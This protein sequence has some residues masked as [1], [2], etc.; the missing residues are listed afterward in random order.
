MIDLTG[1][2]ILVTGASSGIGRQVAITLSSLGAAVALTGR[3]EQRLEETSVMLSGKHRMLLP[4]DLS[5]D[6]NHDDLVARFRQSLGPIDGFVHAAGLQIT[7]PLRKMEFVDYE[8]LMRVNVFAALALAK[9]MT[10]NSHLSVNGGS[11]VFV[12]SVMG[13]LSR[14]ALTAYSASK[15]A[16]LSGAKALALELSKKKVRVN[17][18]LPG[19]VMTPL[20]EKHVSYLDEKQTA[21]RAEKYPL[22]VGN[23]GDVANVCAFLVSDAARWITGTDI[24]VDGG[25][26][27]Q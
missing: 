12:S 18:V 22:G 17:C 14:P 19:M 25:Y 4:F 1:K 21:K 10:R 26:C 15:G 6:S 20:M 23:P 7:R 27:A 8:L 3:D 5:S 13:L 11:I 24:I 2:V 9:S 16:L